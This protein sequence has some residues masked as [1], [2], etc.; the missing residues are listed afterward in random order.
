ME[1]G[2]ITYNVHGFPWIPTPIKYVVAWIVDNCSVIAMQ[3]VWCR[4]AEWAAAFREHGWT[5]QGAADP[6]VSTLF[7]SG[8]ACA[9]SDA[10]WSFQ[11]SRCYP[12]L[13]ST[14]LDSFATKGWFRL[15]LVEK[16]SGLPLR[17]LNTHLQADV[18][19]FPKQFLPC[20]EAIRRKQAQQITEIELK[21]RQALTIL[22]GDLN[23]GE[24][25]FSGFELFPGDPRIDEFTG[26]DHCGFLQGQMWTV[27]E[28]RVG[29]ETR[30]WS[31]HFPILFRL[32]N[33]GG[34]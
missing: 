21:G 10:V 5:F 9:W 32:K 25:W 7:G 31:D 15:V 20:S 30:E 29:F 8:L 19:M 28:R 14:G 17:I 12:F 22:A 2:I 23:T 1:V 4:H 3:E 6:P 34:N 33:V 16:A 11:D 13:T 26:I 18:D 24:N 27:V